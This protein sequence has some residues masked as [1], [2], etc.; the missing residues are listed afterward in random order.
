[1]LGD[2]VNSDPQIIAK[3]DYGYGGTSGD[4]TY[5]TFLT[6][7][8][9]E[10][11]AVGA[12]EGFFHI[13]DATPTTPSGTNTSGGELIGF[14]PQAAR[15]N[16]KD[17]AS[18]GYSHRYFV[19]GSIG[20][21]H[22][23][24]TV[25]GDPT[26]AW[27]TVV[28]AAGGAGAQTV[29][30]INAPNSQ[31]Y[32]ANN[33]LW[34]INGNTALPIANT[35]G[36]VMGRPAIGKLKNGT[37]VAIFGNG[38]NST[39]GTANLF[40]VRL[41]D[42]FILKEIRTDNLV[43]GN[44]L[45][46]T[47]IVKT[48]SGNMDTIDYVYGA[49]YKGNIWRFDISNSTISSWP[50]TGALI[51]STPTGRP[52]TAEIKVGAATGSAALTGGKMVYFGTGTYL[53]S[54][55]AT[56]TSPSQALY[57]IYDDLQATSNLS[58]AAVV[59]TNLVSMT[60]TMP[61]ATGDTRT[62]STVTT[63]WYNQ[64][65]KKGWVLPLT[66]TNVTAGERVIAPPVRYTVAGKVD[67]FLFTSIVPG[68]DE[69]AA[70]VDAWITGI[71]AMTGGYSG[72]FD[73]LAPNSVKIV[74]GSPRG[75]FVLQD[76]GDPALYI[77]QTIFNNTISTTTFTTSTGGQQSVTINGTVG[78]TQVLGIKLIKPTVG[79]TS[80]RQSWRQLK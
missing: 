60:L 13:F 62:S 68:T 70:G 52:I 77:S 46:S 47:E 27:R 49:D 42:G 72:V 74:G 12:N 24:I 5:D 55:D 14:M 78:K 69:C 37:W 32:S 43:T 11:L 63:P 17:L 29:F 39:A 53:N 75:V 1:M 57:G 31:S 9:T 64:A 50:A 28:V 2:I 54:T 40:V 4:T 59:D 34:E 45:G 79:T 71:D 51:Y 10:S 48:T 41:S 67:A 7:L 80:T 73:G 36:N 23:K 8:T 26:T 56:A 76:G 16:I 61:S 38:Y 35:L 65:G 30:A 20:Q 44:G 3:K 22:A 21:G 66:G 58:P 6:T 18:P 25:P 15:T 33:V 19:D